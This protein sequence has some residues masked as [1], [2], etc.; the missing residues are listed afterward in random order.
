MLPSANSS[1]T[2][3][4]ASKSRQFSSFPHLPSFFCYSAFYTLAVLKCI[5]FLKFFRKSLPEAPPILL[6]QARF[7]IALGV[8]RAAL[9]LYDWA[10]YIAPADTIALAG[11]A[12]T[13]RLATA[14]T[15]RYWKQVVG[16]PMVKA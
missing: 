6:Q 5:R 4:F 2:Y 14:D 3:G 16:K 7:L 9:V 11:Q 1:P 10:L 15:A 8:P 13:R 12:E